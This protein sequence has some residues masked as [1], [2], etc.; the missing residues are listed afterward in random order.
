MFTVFFVLAALNFLFLFS[1][2]K[3]DDA[4][5]FILKMGFG[6]M[7]VLSVVCLLMHLGFLHT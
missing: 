4:L 6:G 2:W 3:R 1:I 5:N 7:L